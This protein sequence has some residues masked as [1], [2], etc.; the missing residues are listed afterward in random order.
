[1]AYTPPGQA[2]MPPDMIN[3]DTVLR[4]IK[5]KKEQL[6]RELDEANRKVRVNEIMLFELNNLEADI[7]RI[8]SAPIWPQ[9]PITPPGVPATPPPMARDI[10]TN[11]P[12]YTPAAGFNP[13]DD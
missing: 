3:R 2:T 8:K 13:D 4:T 11:P 7:E 1:M 5:A 10:S 6:Q 9:P 12:G